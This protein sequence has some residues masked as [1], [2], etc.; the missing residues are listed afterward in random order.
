MVRLNRRV[1]CVVGAILVGVVVAGLLAL[2][3]QSSRLAYGVGSARA[4]RLSPGAGKHR[5]D[6][7]P[8]REPNVQSASA[9]R[10][11]ETPTAPLATPPPAKTLS[12]GELESQRRQRMLRPAMS[13]PIAAAAF[14][15]PSLTART[16]TPEQYGPAI[17][18]G[19]ATAP[20][21]TPAA[22]QATAA[23][24]MSA[25]HSASSPT[26]RLEVLPATLRGLASRY[27]VNAGTV[28]PAILLTGV[29]SDL[30][31]QLIGQIREPVFDTEAGQHLLIP[32]GTRLIGL[33]DHHVVYGQERILVTW[34][35]V[36]L[37]QRR[38]PEPHGRMPGTDATGAARFHDEMSLHLLRVFGNALLLTVFTTGVQLSQI[39]D[40]GRGFVGP[41]AGNVL[42]PR[43]GRT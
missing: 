26:E 17:E 12:D 13:A 22:A 21:S 23:G 35:R 2:Q 31:G 19:H 33:D 1:L 11:Y 24:R 27:E 37:L 40:Y 29:N 20:A 36:A 8:N 39:P 7:V 10:P 16:S 15:A 25:P 5:F 41:S 42:G 32:Q 3:A 34:R 6:T 43:S 38:E 14:E 4:S 9:R 28:I 18:A 30:P